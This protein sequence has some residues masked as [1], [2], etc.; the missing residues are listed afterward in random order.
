MNEN[1]RVLSDFSTRGHQSEEVGNSPCHPFGS[2]LP[3]SFRLA[4]GLFQA[5]VI[6]KYGIGGGVRGEEET[7][8]TKTNMV[9]NG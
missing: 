2:I 1:A 5:I 7:R 8:Q 3:L 4:L 9:E 6:P